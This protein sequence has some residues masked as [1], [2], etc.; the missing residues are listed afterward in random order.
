ICSSTT[1]LG[2]SRMK[3]AP[4]RWLQRLA[5]I[6]EPFPFRPLSSDPMHLHSY[7]NKSE[8]PH[9]TL[10][11]RLENRN[12]EQSREPDDRH[13]PAPTQSPDLPSLERYS[14]RPARPSRR[15]QGAPH[16]PQ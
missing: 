10:P 11:S 12:E 9:H 14:W 1:C 4:R 13:S 5:D 6:I 2:D 7:L 16:P 3:Y 8:T 15:E